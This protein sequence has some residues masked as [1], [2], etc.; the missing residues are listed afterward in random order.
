[1]KPQLAEGERPPATLSLEEYLHSSWSPDCEFVDG[2]AE[3]R[4]VGI[5]S[6]ALTVGA[7]LWTLTDRQ[8][9]WRVLPLPSL[10][11]RVSPTRVRVPDVCVIQRG[12]PREQVLTHPP[13]AVFEVL[14]EEDR[15]SASMEKLGDYVRF[16]VENIWIIDPARRVAYRYDGTSLEEIKTGELIVQ[17]TPIRVDLG[18]MFAELN[19]L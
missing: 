15:F 5:M 19:R 16:G 14:D 3:E 6:H 2:R 10:R 9:P 4:N 7:L 13:Q 18:E 17:E 11:M 12:G 1:M 8:Q